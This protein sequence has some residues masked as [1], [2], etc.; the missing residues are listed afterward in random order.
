M[1]PL[2][3]AIL[4]TAALFIHYGKQRRPLKDMLLLAALSLAG[5]AQFALLIVDKPVRLPALIAAVIDVL[6]FA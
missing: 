4:V 1:T 5:I 2:L 3:L 6:G